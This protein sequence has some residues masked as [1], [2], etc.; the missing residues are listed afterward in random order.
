VA[1]MIEALSGLMGGR[2]RWRTMPWMVAM[3]GVLVVPLGV[4]SLVLVILQP[5]AVGAWCTLCLVTAVAMLVMISP[6][7]DEVVATAQFLAAARREGRP[8]W[9]TFWIGGTLA[10]HAGSKDPAAEG[11]RGG[12]IARRII[13][14]VDLDSVP[15]NM[16]VSAAAGVWVM[17]APA[18]LGATGAGAASDHVAGALIVTWSVIAFG[19]IARS[20]RWLN[21]PM[22]LWIAAAPWL[23]DG[24]TAS[25]RWN[26][27]AVGLAL[28]VLAIPRGRVPQRFGGWNRS[29]V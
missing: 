20:A 3:F 28:I 6:A 29:I 16:L 15:W 19:Q 4:V 17:A 9:R 11:A 7:L 12:S 27:V 22:G 8:F 21:V 14:A 26:D 18:A 10:G 1:Y 24:D 13:G 5:V 2:H 25:S 23:L